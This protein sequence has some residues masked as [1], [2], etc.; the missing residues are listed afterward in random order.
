MEKYFNGKFLYGDD[1]SKEEIA[2]WYEQE[3]EAYADLY[4]KFTDTNKQAYGYHNLN[5]FYA[6]KYLN[7]RL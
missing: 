4:G 7:N 6:Y 5:M 3:A 2:E 1:F